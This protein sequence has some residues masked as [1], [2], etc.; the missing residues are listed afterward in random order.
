M[1]NQDFYFYNQNA[2][3]NGTHVYPLEIVGL[4]QVES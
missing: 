4:D 1:L 2:L 3:V